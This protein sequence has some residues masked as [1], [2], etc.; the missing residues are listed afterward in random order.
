VHQGFDQAVATRQPER[1]VLDPCLQ[2]AAG[3]AGLAIGLVVLQGAGVFFAQANG[4]GEP[5]AIERVGWGLG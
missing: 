4:L 5:E 2:L 1:A 3:G